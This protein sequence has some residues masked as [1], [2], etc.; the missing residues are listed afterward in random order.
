MDLDYQSIEIK[1]NP[2]EGFLPFVNT[3]IFNEPLTYIYIGVPNLLRIP[4]FGFEGRF[5]L[6]RFAQNGLHMGSVHSFENFLVSIL[7]NGDSVRR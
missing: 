4:D 6:I 1:C 5:D 7:E 3:S 2:N